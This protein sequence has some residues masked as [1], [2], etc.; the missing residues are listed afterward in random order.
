MQ[1]GVRSAIEAVAAALPIAV[2]GQNPRENAPTIEVVQ[3]W[4]AFRLS[5][6]LLAFVQIYNLSYLVAYAYMLCQHFFSHA[7]GFHDKH[8]QLFSNCVLLSAQCQ[9]RW[10]S[11][12]GPQWECLSSC[13]PMSYS[14]TDLTSDTAWRSSPFRYN[15]DFIYVMSAP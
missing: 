5:E 6:S 14:Q 8:D 11:G 15:S 9:N 1:D 12:R 3:Y 13:F 10:Q 7:T 4:E 2:C